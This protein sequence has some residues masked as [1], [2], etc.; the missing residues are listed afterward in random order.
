[1]IDLIEVFDR[2]ETGPLTSETDYYMKRYVPKLAEVIARHKVKWDKETII[3]TDDTLTDG[4]FEA[5]IDL[6]AEAGAYCPETNRVMQFTREEIVLACQ[7]APKG[8]TFGEG[9]E[10]KTMYGR[11]PDTTDDRPWVHVGGGIYTTDE[12]IFVDTVEKMASYNIVDSVSVPS[13]LH[14]RGKDSRVRS[15][16]EILAAC[17]TVRLAREG[18]RRSGRAGHADHQ[19]H[20]RRLPAGVD[21]RRHVSRV[22]AARRATAS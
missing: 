22:R 3:N 5:A 9:R 1:M 10:R 6:I 4:V 13:I 14:L 15:P 19:R 21:V 8:A 7:Q 20:L 2:A 17:K 12:Q 18:I 11:R 16:Q